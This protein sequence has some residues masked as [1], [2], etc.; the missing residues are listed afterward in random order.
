MKPTKENISRIPIID[1]SKPKSSQSHFKNLLPHN[2]H[3]TKPGILNS[4][5]GFTPLET[6]FARGYN[7]QCS[8]QDN[9]LALR[10]KK[11]LRKRKSRFLSLTGF[12]PIRDINA[13]VL[14]CE[15][16]ESFSQKTFVGRS[17]GIL[18]SLTGFTLV[19]IM[20]AVV[21]VGIVSS[22]AIPQ[23][24]N[25]RMAANMESVRQHMRII[26][27]KMN[28]VL[29]NRGEF[30]PESEW[31]LIGTIDPD[32]M[33]VTASLSAIDDLCYT[34]NDYRTTA[35][36]KGYR[37]CSA[38]QLNACGGRA[39]HKRFC[40]HYDQ[41]M[42]AV[43]SAG[44]VG[45]VP[46]WQFSSLY[47]LDYKTVYIDPDHP[48]E[49]PVMSPPIPEVSFAQNNSEQIFESAENFA[50]FLQSMALTQSLFKKYL[51]PWNIDPNAVTTVYFGLKNQQQKDYYSSLLP[52]AFK[53]LS[54]LGIELYEISSHMLIGNETIQDLPQVPFSVTLGFR[55]A[56]PPADINEAMEN[57]AENPD[58]AQFM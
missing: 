33:V 18:K 1:G 17:C 9:D 26:A 27:Q 55:I 56:N 19:E 39:G 13:E 30:P 6:W 46:Y 12:T 36:G 8:E 25:A 38:P 10:P 23:F 58:C 5:T 21:I 34:T 24:M 49:I 42:S 2:S 32:E 41:A 48:G 50:G 37:F 20:T 3:I 35:N 31:P 51:F 14:T 52:K 29:V 4:V 54:A 57:C 53:L 7:E 28:D 47:T 45:E 16:R 44:T 15:H 40:V 43:I 11:G 22:I